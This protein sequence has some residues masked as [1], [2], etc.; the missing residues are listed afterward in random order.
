MQI[1]K[2]IYALSF[3]F[4]IGSDQGEVSKEHSM[5][6]TAVNMGCRTEQNSC[7]DCVPAT[8]THIWGYLFER[9]N[10]ISGCE[11]SLSMSIGGSWRTLQVQEGTSRTQS[12]PKL[13][14]VDVRRRRSQFGKDYEK[15]LPPTSVNTAQLLTCYCSI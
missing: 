10:A 4:C 13:A 5:Q 2:Q 9:H 8:P 12:V 3:L 11:S 7:S 15:I 6:Q 1:Q 14:H